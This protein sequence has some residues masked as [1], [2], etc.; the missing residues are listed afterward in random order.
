[1]E[2]DY[3]YTVLEYFV[4]PAVFIN[5]I[6]ILYNDIESCV[7]NNDFFKVSRGVRQGCL[8]SPYLFVLSAEVLAEYIRRC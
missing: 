5:W 7:T 8:L 6:S 3:I 2:W 4:F 1:M